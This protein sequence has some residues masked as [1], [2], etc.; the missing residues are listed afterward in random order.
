MRIN[1][2]PPDNKSV[3]SPILIGRA[4]Q[5]DSII[6][7]LEESRGHK[8]TVILVSGEAGIGKSR[9][10]NETKTYAADKGLTILQGNCFEPDRAL[11]YAPFLDLLRT[12]ILTL[13][14]KQ[15]SQEFG[16]NSAEMVQL[17]P[18]LAGSLPDFLYS[19][20][21][22]PESEKHR[23]FQA[24]T[25]FFI[26]QLGKINS[27][28]GLLI[29]IED[30]HW[31]D[32]TSLEFLLHLV[33][34]IESLPIT[35]LVTYR[36]DETNPSLDK[37][38]SALNRQR[39]AIE[40]HLQALTASELDALMRAIFELDHPVRAEFLE[41][42]HALT[43]GNPFFT[44]EILK[45]LIAA[46]SFFYTNGNWDN[47]PIHELDIPHSIQDAVNRR[48]Q[49]LSPE[50][51]QTLMLAAVAGRRFDFGLL[52]AV[53]KLNELDLLKNM[54]ELVAAQ[55]VVEE[56]AD[57]FAFRHALTREA[58][59]AR[60]LLRERKNY[61]AVIAET[62]ENIHADR[63]DAHIADLS[64]HFHQAGVWSKT[65]E[66]SQQAGERAQALYAPREAIVYFM[67]AME[68]A[69]QLDIAPPLNMLRG[70]GQAYETIGDFEHAL[71]DYEQ[72]LKSARGLQ[73]SRTEW[74]GLI[75]LGFLWAGR[76]YQRTG[77]LFRSAAELAET[78]GDPKLLATSLNRLGNWLAN[79]GECDQAKRTHERALEIYQLQRDQAGTAETFDLL[80]M[81]DI[82]AGDFVESD[83]YY[84][85]SIK[86]FRELG[87]KR[88][89]VSSLVAGSHGTFLD[90]TIILPLRSI[91][92]HQRGNAEA[93]DLAQQIDWP[94]GLAF[95][96][97]AAGIS[98]AGVGEFGLALSHG[99]EALRV[100]TLSEHRQWTTGAYYTL[101]HIYNLMYQPDL[102]LQNLE[103]GLPLALE[104]ASSWWIGNITTHLALAYLLKHDIPRSE[105]ILQRAMSQEQPAHN[106]PE[107]RMKWAW[108]KV[109]LAK[110]RPQEALQLAEELIGSAPGTDK[111][112]FIPALLTL[113]AEAL[114]E[115]RH[116]D[117]ARQVLDNALR[118]AEQR[119]ARPW[120]WEI[121]ATRGRLH[122]LLKEKD[123][124][125]IEFSKARETAHAMANTIED[126]SM[127]A[128]FLRATAGTL[129]NE[130]TKTLRQAEKGKFGGLTMR[131]REVALLIRDG[132]S[133]REIADTLIVSE[134]TIE[135]HVGSILQ[136]LEYNSR[137]QIA[138][139]VVDKGLARP[140]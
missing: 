21:S 128:D 34:R 85:Q 5:F 138:A 129:P 31:G 55:L 96:E 105:A 119:N 87:D 37:L 86:L 95:A 71:A 18:E 136:K 113:K 135:G 83:H 130:K 10:V 22:D 65:I 106:L 47:K 100:A 53:T 84:Q 49:Q 43:E 45:S 46:G 63:L 57:Q 108:A 92:E 68:A 27:Q 20:T 121:R 112:Q 56:S 16:T 72:V 90:E 7:R 66:Y 127:R 40:I 54:K 33:R 59:Y 19:P 80:G 91:E 97:W 94:S 98:M 76:D 9:L 52:Q 41:T 2:L 101:G 60:L 17:I 122:Q 35:L 39:L 107:R 26:R 139:W 103:L 81:V 132:K 23:L 12:F 1:T 120:L 44:E 118:G 51:R 50:A 73:D 124:A 137:S 38:L 99:R 77:E 74:Q 15:I 11:P 102:A 6:E 13:S 58:T 125:N 79:V 78:T 67:R 29:I 109:A 104:L 88:G 30:L 115:L 24:L 126:P 4:R 8:G 111:S 123:L 131:E 25:Q 110:G 116:M 64:Y 75:D 32:D 3:I 61:H 140:D 134:R 14:P 36:N 48:T 82:T 93:S 62:I 69:Q 42:I 114:I 89:L 133:N 70:R 28:A 117:A